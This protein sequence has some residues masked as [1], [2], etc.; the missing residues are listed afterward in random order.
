MIYGSVC[1]G[2]EAASVAWGPLKWTPAWFSEIEDF[3][4]QVLKYR[5]KDVLNLGDMTK[6]YDNPT[7]K[8][9]RI[10]L[11]VGGTPCQ[12]F[13][14]AGERKGLEDDRG[15]L[16][17][18]FLKI[19][20]EK[21]P[22][23][24]VWEN[25]PGVLSSGD[26]KDFATILQEMVDSGYGVAYRMLDARHF[27]LP[28]NRRRIFVVGHSGGEWQRAAAVLFERETPS[29]D[30]AGDDK[31][32]G[33]IPVCTVRN[34]GNAN[35]RGVV[36]AESVGETGSSDPRRFRLEE[37]Q[38]AGESLLLRRLTP[39][40]EEQRMGFPGDWTAIP[41]A[42]DSDRYKAIGNSMAVPV[43]RWIGEGIQ[44]VD[45]IQGGTMRYPE[46][47][48]QEARDLIAAGKNNKEVVAA[49]GIKEGTISQLRAELKNEQ[50]PLQP[51]GTKSL[52]TLVQE[53]EGLKDLVQAKK[54][55]IKQAVETL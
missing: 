43:M 54:D 36:V 45:Q 41:N 31:T 17:L 15:N 34:A 5:F 53:L 30:S 23:W 24:I 7:F 9:S 48:K 21:Q 25:V 40:E 49:T 6:I 47:K 14:Q 11:L 32:E 29:D 16:V 50:I 26:G 27:S 35:A 18:N 12:S 1:S 3:P 51:T 42:N 19:A 52:Q 4:C 13:S 28:Q 2:I 10:D 22:R 55:E 38:E 20:R 46:E 44:T 39:A 8:N 33:R 37:G